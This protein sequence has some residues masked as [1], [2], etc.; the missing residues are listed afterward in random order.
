MGL[1]VIKFGNRFRVLNDEG[2]HC[3]Q[4][5]GP[6][7]CFKLLPGH[8]HTLEQ[9]RSPRHAVEYANE[10]YTAHLMDLYENQ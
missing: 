10:R 9:F 2:C 3:V 7:R 4:K 1:K 6:R 5:L 8:W